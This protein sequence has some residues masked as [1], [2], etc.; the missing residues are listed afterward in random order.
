MPDVKWY[1]RPLRIAALQCNYEDG[2]NLEVVDRWVDA[3]FNTE[4]LFHPMADA[5]SALFDEARHGELLRRYLAKTAKAGLHVILYANVHIIGPTDR[6]R[7]TEWG[8]RAA[9]GSYPL[10]YDTYYACCFNGAWRDHFLGIVDRLASYRLDGIFLDGPVV[11]PG[12]CACDACAR[13]F[14]ERTG[15]EL[16]AATAEERFAFYRDTKDEFLK[17]AYR[18][19]KEARPQGLFYINLPVTSPHASYVSIPRALEYNDIVGSEGGFMFYGPA[20]HAPLWK[21]SMRAKVLEAIAPD[22]PRVVFMA[23]DHKPWSWYPHSPTET[24]LA[25]ASSVANAAGIWY[26]LHGSTRLLDT[27]GCR[28]G[29]QLMRFLARNE[30]YYT[31]TWSGARVAVLYSLDTDR[32][33]RS[34]SERSDFYGTSGERRE[35]IGDYGRALS[36]V[37]DALSRSSIPYDMVTDLAL[38][39]R[40]LSRYDLVLLPSCACLSEATV[41]A[42][43]GYVRSGG[44]LI[45]TSDS[46]LYTEKGERRPDLGLSDV[47]GVRFLGQATKYRDHDYFSRT[48]VETGLF[49]GLEIPYVPCAGFALE[50]EAAPGAEVIAR[51]HAP[52]PGRYVDLTPQ[53]SPA[54][55]RNKLGKGRSLYLAG[56]FGEMLEEYALPEH[57]AI[58]ANAVR[59]LAPPRL[60]LAG[61]KPGRHPVNVEMVLRRQAG[62]YVVHLVNYAG[63]VPRPFAAVSVQKGLELRVH[64][65]IKVRSALALVADK[66]CDIEKGDGEQR[67]RLP[68]LAEYEVIVLETAKGGR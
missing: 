39:E 2:K 15:H 19:F 3:G 8:Q 63:I 60:A 16:A 53:G 13:L 17:E 57:R 61:R 52:M 10:L 29:T 12:G 28:A 68:A 46:S 42:I 26:G 66:K 64:G 55:V 22:K 36:G 65:S 49:H 51:F 5:Y 14:R 50:V 41:Q 24:R 7:Y 37:C 44:N 6:H 18:R 9:D 40:A 27:P 11:I 33:Y 30:R 48:D 20:R 67:V 56:T 45:A 31:R 38:D 25:I 23:A 59:D 35:A 32:E 54:V 34:A 47:L 58:V 21:P 4:Q 43:R 62:R 1:E